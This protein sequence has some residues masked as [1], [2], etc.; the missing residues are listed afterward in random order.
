M[1]RIYA[2]HEGLILCIQYYCKHVR[3]S[4]VQT[5][6]Q[7]PRIV[8]RLPSRR[9]RAKRLSVVIIVS[10]FPYFDQNCTRTCVNN[11]RPTA[12]MFSLFSATMFFP[13]LEHFHKVLTR[14]FTL[15]EIFI[16]HLIRKVKQVFAKFCSC[17]SARQVSVWLSLRY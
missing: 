12:L 7:L 14:G 16:Q 13:F 1:R 9:I 15:R 2:L 10:G 17:E 4:T 5:S 11:R 8:P 3:F 6:I